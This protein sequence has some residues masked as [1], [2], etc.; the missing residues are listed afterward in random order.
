AFLQPDIWMIGFGGI[1]M[2]A[3]QT[4]TITITNIG[5]ATASAI[6]PSMGGS[7]DFYFY[8]GSYPGL[9]GTCAATLAPAASCT[10]VLAYSPAVNSS[11]DAYVV[12]SYND[13]LVTNTLAVDMNGQGIT[14][15]T[16]TISSNPIYNFGNVDIGYIVN[17]TLTVTNSG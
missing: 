8:G 15:A 9:G 3:E 11:V 4:Q 1:T 2:G 16:L 5:V 6:S 17:A 12:F 10:V 14:P 7:A 13:S